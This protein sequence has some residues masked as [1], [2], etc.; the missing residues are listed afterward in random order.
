MTALVWKPARAKRS[1]VADVGDNLGR[2]VIEHCKSGRFELR[3]H[4]QPIGMFDHRRERKA[5][6][7]SW[8]RHSACN[9]LR[10]REPT[11]MRPHRCTAL[12]ATAWCAQVAILGRV[13]PGRGWAHAQRSGIV[14]IGPRRD[15]YCP[16]SRC[17]AA[18][19]R[20]D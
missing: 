11:F 12:T 7:T 6:S 14:S 13:A 5:A 15:R 9:G 1:I 20:M 19:R 8:R 2:Y 17:N 16:K 4:G 18:L 3:L 10:R